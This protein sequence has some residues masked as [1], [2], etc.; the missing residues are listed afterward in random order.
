MKCRFC[1][2]HLSH[3][4]CDLGNTPLSNSYLSNEIQGIS[5]P[6]YPLHALICDKCLLV[7]V[8][9]FEKPEAIFGDY[10]YFSSYSD[11]WLEH[12][13]KYTYEMISR[14]GLNE[15][16]QVVEIASND[17]YL[18][19]FFLEKNIPILGIEPAKNVASV[20]RSKGIPTLT[21]FFGARLARE[22]HLKGHLII[23]NNVLA[24]VPDLNDFVEGIKISLAENGVATLEFP[25]LLKLIQE[26]QFDTIYHEHFS[27]FSF[28]TVEKVFNK[29]GLRIFDV[30]SVPTHGGSLRIYG[31]HQ[32]DASK[33]NHPR[34]LQMREMEKQAGLL[35]LDC[36]LAFDRKVQE[37]KIKLRALLIKLKDEGKKVVAYG[38][39]AKGNTLLN[40]CSVRT[41]LIE[42]TVDR[43]PHKQNKRLPGSHI[44]IYSPDKIKID[45]PHYILILPWNIKEEIVKQLSFAK[46]WGCK[47]IVPIPEP[48][49]LQ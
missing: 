12:V 3:T 18:L 6:F 27:Y 15:R 13:R 21:E 26:N 11:S 25:H 31:C 17:G 48:T 8:G 28:F 22:Q 40:Y 44:P 38:A 14:F 7:Q 34:V 19:Q 29:Q 33:P 20:A 9:E 16:S 43:S 36:Y 1:S 30:E 32:E 35:T 41:D 45:K 37:T 2:S 5:E 47:F 4:F 24:H 46:D 49:V 23:A 42:Y 10:S 39:P